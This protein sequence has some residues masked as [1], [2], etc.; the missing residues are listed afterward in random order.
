M[1]VHKKSIADLIIYKESDITSEKNTSSD[2][3]CSGDVKTSIE[4]YTKKWRQWKNKCENGTARYMNLVWK[5]IRW[6]SAVHRAEGTWMN[7]SVPV[8]LFSTQS[9]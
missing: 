8:V 7:R 5:S 3:Q 6:L 9:M 2:R 4:N 1:N